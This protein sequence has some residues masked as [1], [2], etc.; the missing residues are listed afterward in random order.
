MVVLFEGASFLFS[1][2]CFFY[3]FNP[4]RSFMRF[5]K[6]ER[7][8]VPE[9]GLHDSLMLFCRNSLL[10]FR[11]FPSGYPAGR[12]SG[13]TFLS[14]MTRAE[15]ILNS[16]HAASSSASA[17]LSRFVARSTLSMLPPRPYGRHC[18]CRVAQDS[19]DLESARRN[20]RG[21]VWVI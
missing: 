20:W 8:L 19:K 5:F 13:A 7:G 3:R 18:Q 17:A 15:A 11:T 21:S 4:Y 9:C 6:V 10:A 2:N 16:F 1:A 14:P 12:A